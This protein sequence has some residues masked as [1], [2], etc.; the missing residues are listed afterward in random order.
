VK[1]KISLVTLG[2]A[3]VER[4]VRFYELL[5]WKPRERNVGDEVAFFDMGGVHLSV[6]GQKGLAADGLD[7]LLTDL[8]R[9]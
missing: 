8:K 5:G 7:R 9:A 2:V 3:D 4:S 1:Q 6:F